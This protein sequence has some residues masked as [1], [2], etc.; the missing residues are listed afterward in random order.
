[1]RTGPLPHPS[2]PRLSPPASIAPRIDANAVSAEKSAA[3]AGGI[4]STPTT[5][6][7]GKMVTEPDG[8]SAGADPTAVLAAIESA[9]NGK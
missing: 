3:V 7:N 9:V 2:V 5:I 1:V 6:V 8:T 4:Q